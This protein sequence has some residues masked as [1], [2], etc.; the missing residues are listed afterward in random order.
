M[1]ASAVLLTASVPF[2]ALGFWPAFM[3]R[4]RLSIEPFESIAPGTGSVSTSPTAD[5][6]AASVGGNT[7]YGGARLGTPTAAATSNP[8]DGQF[9]GTAPAAAPA[10]QSP[11]VI[12]EYPSLVISG[13]LALVRLRL[14]PGATGSGLQTAGTPGTEL[15]GRSADLRDPYAA[16]NIVAEADLDLAGMELRPTG[17]I[18][19]PLAPGTTADFVW[20]VR[21]RQPATYR[22]TVWLFLIFVDRMTGDEVREAVSAQSVQIRG[23]SLL[24]LSGAATRAIG[25]LTAAG[26][27]ILGLPFAGALLRRLLQ[28]SR[29]KG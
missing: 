2:L 13:D 6:N 19:E 10:G 20:S 27:V 5:N 12:L 29:Q 26:G 16:Y 7:P 28:R 21:S 15:A 17:P 3:Q 11:R 18:S 22:G 1:V 24:G 25:G 14:E 23:G 4:E 8:E 9:P